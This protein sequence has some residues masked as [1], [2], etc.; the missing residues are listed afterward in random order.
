METDTPWYQIQINKLRDENMELTTYIN[1]IQ[2]I[3]RDY[4]EN[5]FCNESENLKKGINF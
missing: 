2:K 1:E 4:L 5:S 3:I